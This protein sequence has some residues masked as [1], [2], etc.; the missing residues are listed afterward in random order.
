M[1]APPL[2]P[3]AS[4]RGDIRYDPGKHDEVLA[5][6]APA[7]VLVGFEGKLDGPLASFARSRRYRRVVLPWLHDRYGSGTLYLAP[8]ASI[9]S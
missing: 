9:S 3:R 4:S 6:S 7:A 5:V 8:S 1:I 2:R